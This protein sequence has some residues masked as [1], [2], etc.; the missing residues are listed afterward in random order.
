MLHP[1]DSLVHAIVAAHADPDPR[2]AR[3]FIPFS[4][5]PPNRHVPTY[6][7]LPERREDGRSNSAL[8]LVQMRFGSTM[9]GPAS[10][11]SPARPGRFAV[12]ASVRAGVA[13]AVSA[14]L[15]PYSGPRECQEAA[16][17]TP[18]CS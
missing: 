4:S 11:A 18:G 10:P 9:R 13:S 12:L 2:V 16:C 1:D 15:R 8:G 7:R 5:T 3:R 17:C 6:L 14:M